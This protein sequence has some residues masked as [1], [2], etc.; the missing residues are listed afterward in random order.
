MLR[1]LTG[2]QAELAKYMSELSERAYY[3]GWMDGLEYALWQV[4]QGERVEYGRASFTRNE[5]SELRRLSDSCA[6]WIVFDPRVE[7]TW[8]SRAEWGRRFS[9]WTSN[10]PRPSDG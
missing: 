3:A 6:G 1:D 8:V 2:A 4:A 10:S 9:L 7:E 5:A